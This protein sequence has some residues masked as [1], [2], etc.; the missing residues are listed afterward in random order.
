MFAVQECSAE[1]FRVPD[2]SRNGRPIC[3]VGA[4]GPPTGHVFRVERASGPVWYAK[5]RLPD[6]RQV[7]KK[8][9]PAW[10]ERG[11][12]PVGW[13]TKRTAEAWLR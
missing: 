8:I 13:Y 7:Q 2:M 12:P 3:G 4:V 11:R 5:H 1:H 10:G 6:G 9:G